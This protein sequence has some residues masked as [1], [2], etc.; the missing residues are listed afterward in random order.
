MRTQ[1]CCL[2]AALVAVAVRPTMLPAADLS[3]GVSR[4]FELGAKNTPPAVQA[5]RAQYEDLKRISPRDPRLDY[6]YGVV[7]LNQHRYADALPLVDKYL[8]ENGE[9]RQ[10]ARV[11]LWALLQDRRYADALDQALALAERFPNRP[12]AK[13][14]EQ[15]S[16]TARFLGKV[17]GYLESARPSGLD[18]QV[19]SDCT[20]QLLA[21]LGDA[22]LPAF[23]EGRQQVADRFA[24]FHHERQADDE[25]RAVAAQ[26]RLAEVA[27]TLEENEAN[28]DAG[29]Q[30]VDASGEQLQDARRA[31]T[32]IRHELSG[33]MQDRVRL[34][35]QIVALQVQIAQIQEPTSSTIVDPSARDPSR[36]QLIVTTGPRIRAD[37]LWRL[38]S[39]AVTLGVLN[40]QALEMDKRILSLRAEAAKALD[41]GRQEAQTLAETQNAVRQ[42]ELRAANLEKQ[43]RRL[44]TQR[45]APRGVLT[46]EMRRLTTYLPFPYDEETQRVLAWFAD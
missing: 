13:G 19:K 17:F 5:A 10:A 15:H 40:R 12:P 6:A 46:A 36:G 28:A 22:Y 39:L 33:L 43:A 38:Q 30:I 3:G 34:G 9:D 11:R 35:A 18:S 37:D 32:V 31:L 23:D 41:K 14:D 21:R 1:V 20:N 45:P 16:E 27:V 29:R 2:A 26:K 7:L 4:L 8:A 25:R 42:A 24:K 44:E